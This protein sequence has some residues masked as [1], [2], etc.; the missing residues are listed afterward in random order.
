MKQIILA[1]ILMASISHSATWSDDVW[2]GWDTPRSNYWRAVDC[3]SGLVQR[4]D[5]LSSSAVDA[6]S[7]RN[8]RSDLVAYKVKT[9]T[10]MSSFM[11]VTNLSGLVSV[12]YLD[13][14]NRCF[15][16]KIPTNYFEYTP[17]RSLSGLGTFDDDSGVG[18]LHGYTNN[19][20]ARGGT[21]FPGSQTNWYTTD[22]GWDPLKV[23]ITN[24]ISTA[25]TIYPV[26]T[27]IPAWRFYGTHSGSGTE[28]WSNVVDAAKLDW[29][30]TIHCTWANY[31]VG[32]ISG[33]SFDA[34]TWGLQWQSGISHM[35]TAH[36]K[37]VH[38]H[39]W[40]D[41]TSGGGAGA[42]H[43]FSNMGDDWVKESAYSYAGNTNALLSATATNSS[44]SH[45]TNAPTSW[46]SEPGV[47]E[48]RYKGY[49][50]DQGKDISV[51]EWE[52]DY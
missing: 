47:G 16:S 22:Y 21:N 33:T 49:F 44:I 24:M 36:N 43:T 17:Q 30:E 12:P 46:P 5:V 48:T 8:N 29:A 27:I 15:I 20:T 4:I 19:D 7:H 1:I 52:F 38:F 35:N 14:T 11:P 25:D 26:M 50:I 34:D 51:F 3:Y 28:S 40:V 39:I 32:N 2:P 41:P 23:L 9:R 45:N 13:P 18:H 31:T 10:I 6:P 37:T 42:V